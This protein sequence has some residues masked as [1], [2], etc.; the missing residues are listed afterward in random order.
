[1]ISMDRINEKLK[2]INLV[3][4]G[5]KSQEDFGVV[6][7]G[8][9]EVTIEKAEFREFDSGNLGLNVGFKIRSDVEQSYGNRWLFKTFFLTENA[10]MV[11]V[12]LLKAVNIVGDIDFTSLAD[13]LLKKHLIVKVVDF[14]EYQNSK[15]ETKQ[16]EILS[17]YFKVSKAGQPK[18]GVKQGVGVSRRQDNQE[19]RGFQFSLG[20]SVEN[21]RQAEYEIMEGEDTPPY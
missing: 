1:M 12:G 14:E 4:E 6:A 21:N 19:D 7:N 16:R 8:E 3:V 2:G 13:N 18:Q 11:L 20:K 10:I 15:G 17:P 5:E 9:Y